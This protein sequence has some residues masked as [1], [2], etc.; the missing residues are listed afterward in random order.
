MGSDLYMEAQN[1]RPRKPKVEWDG[2]D[3]VVSI[4]QFYHGFGER[5]RGPVNDEA[6]RIIKALTGQDIPPKPP[7]PRSNYDKVESV[8]VNFNV[9]YNTDLINKI[10]KAL[11]KE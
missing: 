3:I 2:D 1:W 8:L 5:Y 10:L 6:A 11:D 7:K 9:K 4:D